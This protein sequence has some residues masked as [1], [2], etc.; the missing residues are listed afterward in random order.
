MGKGVFK[1]RVPLNKLLLIG[2]REGNLWVAG[3]ARHSISPYRGFVEIRGNMRRL[4][5]LPI[6][7]P[8]SIFP[9]FS[10]QRLQDFDVS[11]SSLR[12]RIHLDRLEDGI[13]YLSHSQHPGNRPPLRRFTLVGRGRPLACWRPAERPQQGQT[14][15][16]NQHLVT[17]LRFNVIVFSERKTS[18]VSHCRATALYQI[19]M[20]T[21]QCTDFKPVLSHILSGKE[22][23]EWSFFFLQFL[24][25]LS[26][27]LPSGQTVTSSI[28]VFQGRR[29]GTKTGNHFKSLT[30]MITRMDGP[31]W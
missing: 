22:L 23:N 19:H 8:L 3:W 6:T 13:T 12:F 11:R 18:H 1:G 28:S 16:A 14:F 10:R 17:S 21:P 4:G 20:P 27:F 15:R 2:K 26:E 9:A 24:P 25:D 29:G 7:A 31:V 30:V 5:F